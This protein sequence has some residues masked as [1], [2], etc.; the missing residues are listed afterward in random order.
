MTQELIFGVLG[1]LGLFIYGIKLMGE[2]LQKAAGDKMRKLLKALTS[3]PLM[4]VMVGAGVTS[5]I[6][7][8]SATT[9]MLV[10][11]VN[12]GLMTLKQAMGVILGA[13]IGTTITAQIIAFK[14]TDYALPI[15]GIGFLIHFIAKGRFW[16]F[17]GL[18]MFGFGMLFLGLQ[19]MTS[20]ARPMAESETIRHAFLNFSSNP[21]LGVLTGMVATMIVQSSS[22]TVGMVL[23]LASVGLLDLQGAIPLILGDNIGTCVTA[24]L[25]SIGTTVSARRTAVAHVAFKTAGVIVVILLLPLFNKLIVLTSTDIARQ[26]ANA[27]TLF[28]IMIT[29]T[30]LPLL[31]IFAKVVTRVVPGKEVVVEAG[32]KHLEPH[33]LNTP[34]LA[35]DAATKEIVR[36][37]GM[38]GEMVDDAMQCFFKKDLACIRAVSAKED[39]VDSLQE[40]VSNYLV[41]LTQRSLSEGE[42]AKIPAL[43]HSV[44]DIERIGDHA[45]N[46]IELGERKISDNL[47]FSE[48][49]MSEL[50]QMHGEIQQMTA[51]AIK[52]LESNDPEEAK[53]VMQ[54]EERVNKLTEQM[55][56]NHIKRLNEG[57]CRVL[58]GIIFL[59]MLSNF[60]KIGDHLTNVAQAVMGNLQW[61]DA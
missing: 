29:L 8:S 36:M 39:A 53:A 55:R 50:K 1:G 47:P 28:N 7:S 54:K 13:D 3:K 23:T 17:F 25:A 9:V 38:S 32:P 56:Q 43:L 48:Q 2:G 34:L 14:L 21:L 12:A 20:V 5:L 60:E 19:I 49:A 58:S 24:M 26:C 18:F 57:T 31:G 15:L 51:S 59:D 37:A 11:F 41:E 16:K 4:G 30:F 42:S 27:H 35:L 44:N 61:S 40:A 6:Q 52:A 45:E 22:V 33:L 10:G 46:L